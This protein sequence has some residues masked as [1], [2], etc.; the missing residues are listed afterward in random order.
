VDYKYLIMTLAI[1]G[2]WAAGYDLARRA[3]FAKLAP[4]LS[5]GFAAA[6]WLLSVHIAALTFRSFFTGLQIA[7]WGV[8]IVGLIAWFWRP[9]DVDSRGDRLPRDW[10]RAG[11]ALLASTALIAPAAFYWS[12]HDELIFTGHMSIAEEMVRGVYPPRHLTFPEGELHY[13]Y[14]FN[15]FVAAVRLFWGVGVDRAIDIVTLLSWAYTWCLLWK[16]GEEFVGAGRGILT[17]TVTL[18]GGGLPY[19]LPRPA[20][21][22]VAVIMGL[23]LVENSHLNPPIVSYF[24]QHPW[25]VGLP[26]GLCVMLIHTVRQGGIWRQLGLGI[27]LLALSITQFVF[28]LA[29][30][31]ASSAEIVSQPP[32]LAKRV[33][34]FVL[35]AL[36]VILAA[37]RLHGFFA[38]APDHSGFAI[39]AR[40]GI[41]PTLDG[42]I[43]WHFL[44]YGLLLPLGVCGL[45][46]LRQG[47]IFLGLLIAGGLGVMN[48]FEYQHSWDI[49]KFGTIAALALSISASATIARVWSLKSRTLGVVL[50]MLLLTGVVFQ[51]LSF[52]TILAL[53]LPGIPEHVFFRAPERLSPSDLQAVRWL[54]TQVPPDEIVFRHHSVSRAYAQW[55]GLPQAWFDDL[56]KTF[57]FSKSRLNERLRFLYDLPSDPD[58]YFN[59]RIRWFVL[60]STD[61][62]LNEI[63]S[64]WIDQG[65]ARLEKRFGGLSI[66]KLLPPRNG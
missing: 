53:D 38:P 14:G 43:L 3:S 23:G 45:F 22:T 48:L 44:T 36:A 7:T 54:Q 46:F 59:R 27:L 42:T 63:S 57:G 56:V 10:R 4:I 21:T 62:R 34:I 13:H 19:F 18:F 49:V 12:F 26:F 39:I 28:F 32:F 24:F 64:I 55:G 25:T 9:R 40:L 2:I 29:L 60:E 52:A 47:R 15:V 31:A 51:G 1:P 65:R 8:S 35:T 6:L 50:G 66:I 20:G 41:C 5:V 37:S 33:K 58:A 16:I 17:A 11:A 61:T 30:T